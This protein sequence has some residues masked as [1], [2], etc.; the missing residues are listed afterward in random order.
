MMD[1]VELDL[2]PKVAYLKNVL[3]LP[4]LSQKQISR[5][6]SKALEPG[7]QDM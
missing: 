6:I 4:N 7:N 1:L 3:S 2:T 5:Q